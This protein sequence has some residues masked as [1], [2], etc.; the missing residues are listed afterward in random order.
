MNPNC[1]CHAR[2]MALM[3]G[4]SPIRHASRSD[5]HTAGEPTELRFN[6][7]EGN[8]DDEMGLTE[9]FGIRVP[10]GK[11]VDVGHTPGPM[12]DSL[13]TI[14]LSQVPTHVSLTAQSV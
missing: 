13:D 6:A 8:M 2:Y 12:D 11:E 10:P 1:R 3:H 14:H 9:F 7:A 4:A 5:T